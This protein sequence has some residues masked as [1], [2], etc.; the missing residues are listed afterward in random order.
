M[1]LSGKKVLGKRA[2]YWDIHI[3]DQ[4]F[5]CSI[6][7]TELLWFEVLWVLVW[8]GVFCLFFYALK[9]HR[10]I[11]QV[12]LSGSVKCKMGVYHP[13]WNETAR[14]SG[15]CKCVICFKDPDNR[16]KGNIYPSNM[17][18]YSNWHGKC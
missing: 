11:L 17:K 1:F 8:F 13:V 10:G 5:L 3:A 18:Q 14:Q 9:K 2:L 12:F 7:N 4:G 15:H 6:R 16:R